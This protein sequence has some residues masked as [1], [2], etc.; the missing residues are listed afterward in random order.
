MDPFI[1]YRP[2]ILNG[3]IKGVDSNED[4]IRTAAEIIDK[5]K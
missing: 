1:A 5:S 2:A 3:Q 4:Q